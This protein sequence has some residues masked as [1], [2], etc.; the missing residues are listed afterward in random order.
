MQMFHKM[1]FAQV[2]FQENPTPSNSRIPSQ[3][4]LRVVVF[5]EPNLRFRGCLFNSGVDALKFQDVTLALLETHIKWMV[6]RLLSFWE[7][8]N[9]LVLGRVGVRCW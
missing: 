9:S 7:G 6:G 4:R 5:Q 1:C 3:L 2:N 8:L